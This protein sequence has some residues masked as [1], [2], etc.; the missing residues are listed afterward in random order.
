[1]I[2]TSIQNKIKVISIIVSILCFFATG[3]ERGGFSEM[4]TAVMTFEITGDWER[5]IEKVYMD[6]NR[7]CRHYKGAI[8]LGGKGDPHPVETMDIEDEDSIIHIDLVRK[9]GTKTRNFKKDLMDLPEKD[10][11][12]LTEQIA[13]DLTTVLP[14]KKPDKPKKG[15][16][17]ITFFGKPCSVVETAFS[18]TYIW[19]TLILRQETLIPYKKVKEIKDYQTNTPIPPLQFKVPSDVKLMDISTSDITQMLQSV[20]KTMEDQNPSQNPS[21]GGKG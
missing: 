10:Q 4:Q 12:A 1:M 15:L 13:T 11:D 2:R 7:V 21:K 18:K 3:G 5:G 8:R 20:L 17:Q 6:G 16:K 14:P 9:T 19:N